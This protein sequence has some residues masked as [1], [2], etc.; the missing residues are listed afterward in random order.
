MIDSGKAMGFRM[1]YRDLVLSGSLTTVFRPGRAKYEELYK[2]GKVVQGAIIRQPGS[3]EDG[4]EREI[5]PVFTG[6]E[7]SLRIKS[8]KKV[9]LKNLRPVDFF[10]S[11]PDVKDEQDLIYHLGM[12]YNQPASSF[13][14]NTIIIRIEL[15]YLSVKGENYEN[16]PA[17]D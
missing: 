14:P 16:N 10:G 15:E 4:Q 5:D 11:S 12:I 7:I 1:V 3:P 9:L 8:Q 2:P 17:A 6:D 13:S